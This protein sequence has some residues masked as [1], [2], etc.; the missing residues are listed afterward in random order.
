ME[1][2][3]RNY[4]LIRGILESCRGDG[5]AA[6]RSVRRI[7]GDFYASAMDTARIE[8]LRLEPLGADL[9]AIGDV[10]SLDELFRLVARFHR[11]GI[12][13]FFHTDV[14]P[15][16]RDSAV[17][18]F[19]LF[20]GGLSLPDRDYYLKEGFSAQ[21]EAFRAHLARSFA[22]LGE[23][24][25]EAAGSAATVFAI[26]S[27]LATASRTRAELREVEKNYH[28][29]STEEL[30]RTYAN[31]PW[32]T[33]LAEGEL[34]QL[35][36]AI[37]G[38]PEFFEAL[39]RLLPEFTISDWKVYARWHLLLGS[40]RFLHAEVEREHFEFYYKTLMGQ[41]QLEPRWLR[42]AR[43]LDRAIGEAVG[44]LYVERY[45]P[46]EA[47]RRMTELVGDLREVFRGRLARLEWMTEETR[48]RALAKF[49]RFSAK[50]GHPEQFRDYSSIRIDRGDYLGNWRRAS[51][52]EYHRQ[53]V[54][55]GGPVDRTEWGMTPAQVN[56]Y[57]D[58]TKNEIVFPAGILQPPFFD[59]SMDDAVNFGGIGAVIAHEI[60]HGYDDQGRKYGPDGN[61]SEWWTDS[62]A[63]EFGARSARVVEEYNGYEPLPGAHVNGQ[64]TLGENI[65]DIGGLSIAFEALQR[66]LAADPSHRKV[67]DGLTPEQRFFISWAQIWRENNREDN[68]RLRLTVD[69]HSPGRFRAVGPALNLT[70]FAEAFGIPSGS[71]MWRP[72]DRRI[73]IW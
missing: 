8:E 71:A 52:F 23:G 40:A 32:R 44:Q 43:L 41:Q 65:A 36:Y 19:Y 73:T 3:E 70:A 27:K 45:F 55:V 69:P 29:Q 39:D 66:R 47:R 56:A 31:T 21:A 25:A 17:Y 49:D 34:S 24:T 38:Q 48:R 13:G 28:K 46:A 9:A 42:S 22:F 5:E 57:F 61:L 6:P 62:D 7:V 68:I 50:I 15:D 30:L 58:R 33:Y 1:L 16:E 59:P 72:I 53:A 4:Q 67:V 10:R 37:V 14:S 2:S 54:R 60:T 18:A 35:R 63:R 11:G 20:Q 64:L 12:G 51:E 26:E